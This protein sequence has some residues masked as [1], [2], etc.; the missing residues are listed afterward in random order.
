M[1]ALVRSLA[2]VATLAALPAL[3]ADAPD[4]KLKALVDGP[5]RSAEFKA[6]DVVRKPLEALT[7]AGV[8]PG[9]TVI[10]LWPSGATGPRFSHPMKPAPGNTWRRSRA[11]TRPAIAARKRSPNSPPSCKA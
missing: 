9:Q 2:L 10:E 7:W 4:P 8:K 11:R 5:Q 3:A 1:R 6:R